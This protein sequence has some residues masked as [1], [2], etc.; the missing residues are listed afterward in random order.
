MNKRDVNERKKSGKKPI[1]INDGII[2]KKLNNCIFLIND[3]KVFLN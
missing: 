2:I 1:K 3:I